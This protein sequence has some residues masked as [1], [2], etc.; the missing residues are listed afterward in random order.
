MKVGDLVRHIHAP[1]TTGLVVDITQ[2]KVWRTSVLSNRV[3]WDKVN[4]ELHAVVLWSHN[5]A[6]IEVPQIELEV[7]NENR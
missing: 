3:D 1:T 6:T 5:N 2:K 4:P 7:V